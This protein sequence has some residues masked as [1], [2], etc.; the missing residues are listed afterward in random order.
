MFRLHKARPTKSGEK[1][2][3]K[4]SNFKAV[5]VIHSIIF[6]SFFL[7]FF[8]FTST[9]CFSGVLIGTKRM[10]QVVYVHNLFGEWKNHCKDKQSSSSK[11]DLSMDRD[12]VRI[13]LGFRK[14]GFQRDGGLFLQACCCYGNVFKRLI[15]AYR[16]QFFSSM[17]EV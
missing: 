5:Q 8:H 14:K 3:F 4:F 2:D 16:D 1:I 10:G 7:S 15:L 6:F 13:Y 11:W 12:S 9:V 17:I